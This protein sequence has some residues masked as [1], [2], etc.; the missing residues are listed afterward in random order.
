MD[1]GAVVPRQVPHCTYLMKISTLIAKC[2]LAPY[3]ENAIN[4]KR[5]TGVE[6]LLV[7]ED[8]NQNHEITELFLPEILLLDITTNCVFRFCEVAFARP[9]KHF[10]PDLPRAPI[11]VGSFGPEST[12]TMP[13]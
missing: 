7:F 4:H 3:R 11:A 9:I 8:S 12:L 2:Q 13:E 10:A 1:V 6:S 5:P